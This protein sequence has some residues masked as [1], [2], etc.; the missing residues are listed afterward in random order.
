MEPR[1]RLDHQPKG[2]TEVEADSQTSGAQSRAVF[3]F[4]FF[5][6]PFLVVSLCSLCRVQ[7]LPSGSDRLFSSGNP[8]ELR[9]EFSYHF[10]TS[11]LW[12]WDRR[13]SF[14]YGHT[15]EAGRR[16]SPRWGREWWGHDIINV[17][18]WCLE[19]KPLWFPSSRFIL[20]FGFTKRIYNSWEFP[21]L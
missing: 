11:Y 14:H 19:S 2:K 10:W 6:M 8:E 18:L 12:S 9:E 13:G 5:S 3:L 1:T 17:Y 4:P 16:A 15:M 20:I 7:L 21:K